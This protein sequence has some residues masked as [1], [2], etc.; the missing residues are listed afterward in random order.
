MRQVTGRKNL[1]G[2]LLKAEATDLKM[3]PVVF[4][5]DKT[6]EIKKIYSQLRSRE[7]KPTLEE[8]ESEEHKAIDELVFSHLGISGQEKVELVSELKKLISRRAEKSKT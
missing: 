4:N 3:L 2:G 1:G 6:A 5:F 7:A 8:V